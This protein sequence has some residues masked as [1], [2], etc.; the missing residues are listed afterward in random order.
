MSTITANPVSKTSK[1]TLLTSWV[2]R[3]LLAAAFLAAGGAKIAGAPM[4]VQTFDG[5]G[6]G[7]WFRYLTGAIEVVSAVLLLL[8]STRLLAAAAL[9]C[10][11]VG[12]IVTHLAIIGGTPLPAGVLLVLTL[13]VMALHRSDLDGLKARLR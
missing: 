8:P 1:S 7:Q 12:A 10:T 2:V 3:L 5:I 11:M 4:M 13:V 9:A 6:I